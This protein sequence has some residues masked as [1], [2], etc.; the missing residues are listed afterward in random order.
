MLLSDNNQHDYVLILCD[1]FIPSSASV[2]GKGWSSVSGR[3]RLMTPPTTESIAI[4]NIG[5]LSLYW[6]CMNQRNYV[7]MVKLNL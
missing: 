2:S 6:P 1:L 5:M 7:G 3:E 4:T